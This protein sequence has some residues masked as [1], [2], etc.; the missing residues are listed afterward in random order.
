MTDRVRAIYDEIAPQWD[1]R[2]GLVERTLMGEGMRRAL[3]MELRGSVLEIGT[4]TGATLPF[5]IENPA[6]TSFTGSDLSSGMLSQARAKWAALASARPDGQMPFPA[7]FTELDATALPFPDAAFDSVTA[8]LML[9]TVPDPAQTL[10][11]MGRVCTPNGRI[12]LLEHVRAPNPLLAGLQKVLSP[13]QERMLGCHLD[14]PTDRLVRDLGYRIE[15]E[16]TRFFHVFHLIVARPHP[17][18][19]GTTT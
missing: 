1:A 11:E 7:T 18:A 5:A 3:A 8:S 19:K 10:R 2:Q 6:I 12:I 15:R 4:G 13:L 14:R 9:C 17:P 16:E